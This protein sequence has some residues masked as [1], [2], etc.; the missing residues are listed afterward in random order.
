[1]RAQD[2]PSQL[3]PFAKLAVPQLAAAL[4]GLEPVHLGRSILTLILPAEPLSGACA[5]DD[6]D[7]MVNAVKHAIMQCC[8]QV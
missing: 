7:E 5:A 8:L 4:P 1:M 3:S 2:F 6:M